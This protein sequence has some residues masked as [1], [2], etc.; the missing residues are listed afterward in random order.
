MTTLSLNKMKGD[1]LLWANVV[2]VSRNLKLCYVLMSTLHDV[3]PSEV[4]RIEVPDFTN[5]ETLIW[6]TG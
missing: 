3:N 2:K 5:T 1:T 6:S 4:D